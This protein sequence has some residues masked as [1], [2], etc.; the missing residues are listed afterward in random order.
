MEFRKNSKTGVPKSKHNLI[1]N[2]TMTMNSC[3]QKLD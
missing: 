3:E 1:W 2:K